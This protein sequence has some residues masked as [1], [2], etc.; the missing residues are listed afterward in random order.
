[1]PGTVTPDEVAE[2]LDV[3]SLSLVEPIDGLVWR[4]YDT[5]AVDLERNPFETPHILVRIGEAVFT[6]VLACLRKA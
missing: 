4:R 2:I 6:S 3:P 5:V 1:M